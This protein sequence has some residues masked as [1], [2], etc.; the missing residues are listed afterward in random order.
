VHGIERCLVSRE[1]AQRSE[2]YDRLVDATLLK[3]IAA[4]VPIGM[5]LVGSIVTYSRG[6]R[7]SSVLQVA[8]AAC[9]MVVVVAHICEALHLF[10]WMLWGEEDSVGHYLDLTGATLGFTLFPLGYLLQALGSAGSGE[11]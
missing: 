2:W 10:P 8:G 7:A 6:T 4:S 3:S 11:M 5:L 1:T 9:L